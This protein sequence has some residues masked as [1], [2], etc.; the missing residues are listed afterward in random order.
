MG[1]NAIICAICKQHGIHR[2]PVNGP[3]LAHLTSTE[4]MRA[5]LAKQHKIMPCEM[6][7]L[8]GLW[9]FEYPAQRALALH[10]LRL[11]SVFRFPMLEAHQML[12]QELLRHLHA[13]HFA[14]H[15]MCSRV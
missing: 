15:D 5:A 8:L 6:C 9:M 11:D 2:D 14:L 10:Q 7:C 1:L 4:C 3:R 13:P 12:T